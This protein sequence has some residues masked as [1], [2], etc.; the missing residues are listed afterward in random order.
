VSEYYVDQHYITIY[1]LEYGKEKLSYLEWFSLHKIRKLYHRIDGPSME[2][3]DSPSVGP[4]WHLEGKQF[5]E[6]Q[7]NQLIQE[8]KDMPLVLRLIDPRK[9]VREYK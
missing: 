5:S 6:E 1:T 7:F 4:R 8:V 9:W 3:I 2:W